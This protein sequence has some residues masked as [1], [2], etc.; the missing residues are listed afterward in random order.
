MFNPS[1]KTSLHKV[2]MIK[3]RRSQ[4]ILNSIQR[5]SDRQSELTAC[6]STEFADTCYSRAKA[7]A[8]NYEPKSV[9]KPIK[10]VSLIKITPTRAGPHIEDSYK[11]YRKIK[12]L[13]D[14]AVLNDGLKKMR[15][16]IKN[17]SMTPVSSIEPNGSFEFMNEKNFDELHESFE[18]TT[19]LW[20]PFAS[21]FVNEFAKIAEHRFKINNLVNVENRLEVIHKYFQREKLFISTVLFVDLDN[22]PTFFDEHVKL[23]ES[24]FVFVFKAFKSNAMISPRQDNFVHYICVNN[25]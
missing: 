13:N 18:V 14:Y 12:K 3:P 10:Q 16:Q 2:D 20:R 22:W 4:S 9:K 5:N 8:N 25:L 23:S 11:Q 17:A 6:G 7:V 21:D 19:R 24:T 1:R 15:Q